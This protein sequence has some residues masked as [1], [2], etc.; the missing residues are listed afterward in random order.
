LCDSG[1]GLELTQTEAKGGLTSLMVGLGIA[2]S[3]LV[4][5]NLAIVGNCRYVTGWHLRPLNSLC[6]QHYNWSKHSACSTSIDENAVGG[7]ILLGLKNARK[8]SDLIFQ[9]CF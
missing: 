5:H 9:Y 2:C 7:S 8:G 4:F 1:L 3:K 6:V